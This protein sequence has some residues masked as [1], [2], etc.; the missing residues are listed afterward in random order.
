MDPCL[1]LVQLVEKYP[2]IYNN[3][4]PDY[5][6]KDV[7]DKAWAEIAES[8]DWPVTSCQSKW[9]NMRNG[10]VRSIK[11]APDGSSKNQRKMYYLHNEM[12]FLVPFVKVSVYSEEHESRSP[13]HTEEFYSPF[14][15]E[16]CNE[17][18]ILSPAPVTKAFKKPKR[19]RVEPEIEWSKEKEYN[20]GDSRKMFLFSLLP[21]VETLTEKQMRDFR[22]K[23][24][25][26]LEE[27]QTSPS[28]STLQAHQQKYQQLRNT[29]DLPHSTISAVKNELAEETLTNAT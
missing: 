8:M 24:L 5:S 4:L 12:Q 2:C 6:R 27:V 14:D 18:S 17:E 11:L 3:T 28:N 29:L 22:I 25:L 20:K 26:L 13:Q 16:S 21:D 23:V 9:K 15:D 19:R 1:N 7:V 10:F